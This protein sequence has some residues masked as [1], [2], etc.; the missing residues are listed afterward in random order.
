MGV[1]DEIL[2]F[3]RLVIFDLYIICVYLND[4]ILIV[5]GYF[6]MWEFLFFIIIWNEIFLIYEYVWFVLFF[7]RDVK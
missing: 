1:N 5:K 3:R 6:Y 4:L 7:N 2:L